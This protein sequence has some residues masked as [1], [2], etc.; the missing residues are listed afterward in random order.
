M[1]IL[2]CHNLSKEF[3]DV[4]V[5][6][7]VSFRLEARE[8][9]AN[10][11]ANGAGKTTLL[12]VMLGELEPDGGQVVISRDLR[13]GYLAQ[14]QNIDSRNTIREELMSVKQELIDMEKR[15]RGLESEMNRLAGDELLAAGARHI[16]DT[17]EALAKF[18]VM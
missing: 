4:P 16:V 18:I 5:F 10:V 6:K 12:R 3:N 11:G 7:D 1:I 8:K 14:N 2:E 17:P 9:A 15:I 13:I